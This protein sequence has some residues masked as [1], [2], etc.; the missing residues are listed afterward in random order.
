MGLSHG[1]DGIAIQI[2]LDKGFIHSGRESIEM[3]AGIDATVRIAGGIGTKADLVFSGQANP[4]HSKPFFL[5]DAQGLDGGS[6]AGVAGG[7]KKNSV[8][9]ALGE[10]LDRRE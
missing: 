2:V 1:L 9:L 5:E 7:K 10:C 3:S 6:L 8:D 4:F